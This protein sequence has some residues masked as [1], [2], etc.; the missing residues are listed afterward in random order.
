MARETGQGPNEGKLNNQYDKDHVNIDL[1]NVWIPRREY[2]V[3]RGCSST[4][5]FLTHLMDSLLAKVFPKGTNTMHFNPVS[6]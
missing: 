1:G 6:T 4:E 5:H 3:I 2:D